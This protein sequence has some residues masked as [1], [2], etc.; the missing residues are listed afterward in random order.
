MRQVDT[1]FHYR[2]AFRGDYLPD[3]Y[4]RLL[5]DAL[6]GDL[7]QLRT[8]YAVQRLHREAAA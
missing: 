4:E 3:A 7:R 5:L 8:A 2:D 6:N 1:E